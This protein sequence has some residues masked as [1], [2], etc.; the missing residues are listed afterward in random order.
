MVDTNRLKGALDKAKGAVKEGVGDLTSD[1]KLKAEGT[2]DQVK[3]KA[4]A[5]LAGPKLGPRRYWQ[6]VNGEGGWRPSTA[7]HFK[8]Y[9][10]GNSH[11]PTGP[12]YRRTYG[13]RRRRR[14][15]NP[16]R[17][18]EPTRRR[19]IGW[20]VVRWSSRKPGDRRR[21]PCR[22]TLRLPTSRLRTYRTIMGRQSTQPSRFAATN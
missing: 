11:R 7:S 20:H 4:E 9:Y 1:E 21:R 15:S 19:S 14:V 22:H 3:G 5:R 13:W 18:N 2:A 10:G 16:R 8:L 6:G 17:L 12:G